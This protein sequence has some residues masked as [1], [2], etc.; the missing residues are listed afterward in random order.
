[1]TKKYESLTLDQPMDGS[2][3]ICIVGPLSWAKCYG[4]F[5]SYESAMVWIRTHQIEEAYVYPVNAWELK[6]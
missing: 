6:P 4:I 2:R 1:M 3:W 5:D